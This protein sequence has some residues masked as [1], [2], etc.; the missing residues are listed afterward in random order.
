MNVHLA[1]KII[2]AKFM[3]NYK[4]DSQTHLSFQ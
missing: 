4:R 3:N 1:I 2:Q